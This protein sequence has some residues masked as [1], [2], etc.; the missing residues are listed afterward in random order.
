M[1][2]R[3]IED[4]EGGIL[5]GTREVLDVAGHDCAQS[6]HVWKALETT[7][8]TADPPPIAPSVSD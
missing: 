2:I 3:T 8:L 7:P 4:L 5:G 6:G 1:P